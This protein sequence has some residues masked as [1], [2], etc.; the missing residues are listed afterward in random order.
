MLGKNAFAPPPWPSI[1]LNIYPPGN[2]HVGWAASAHADKIA[3]SKANTASSSLSI[4]LSYFSPPHQQK[5]LPDQKDPEAYLI[6]TSGAGK[7]HNFSPLT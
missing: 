2:S 1:N 6:K 7:T 3:M 5:K 4:L